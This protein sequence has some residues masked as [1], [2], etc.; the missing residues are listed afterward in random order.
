[1]AQ[2]EGER[3]VVEGRQPVPRSRAEVVIV[4]P[5]VRVIVPGGWVECEEVEEVEREAMSS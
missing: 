2:R 1:V 4:R 5:D 3:K